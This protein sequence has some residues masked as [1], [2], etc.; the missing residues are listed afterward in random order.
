MSNKL[1][2]WQQSEMSL[3]L[4]IF[5]P[6][7]THTVFQSYKHYLSHHDDVTFEVH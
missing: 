5:A 1:S 3:Y 7:H 4:F 2:I 6:S